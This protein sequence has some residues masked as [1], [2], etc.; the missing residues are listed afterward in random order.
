MLDPMSAQPR[1]APAAADVAPR[2]ESP[3]Y[4][5]WV[6]FVLFWVQAL[7]IVDRH[8]FG[9][10]I[11]G[12][13]QEFGL[14]DQVLGALAGLAFAIFYSVAGIPVARWAD[15]GVRRSIIALSLLLW[16]AMT[17]ACGLAQ[18]AWQLALARVLVG[19]GEAGGSPPTHSLVTDYFPLERRG[20]AMGLVSMGGSVGIVISLALG[21]WIVHHWGWREAFLVMGIPGIALAIVI[22]MSLREPPRGRFDAPGTSVAPVSLGETFR[23]LVSVPAFLHISL[24]GSLYSLAGY[25]G[26]IWNPTFLGRVHGLNMAEAGIELSLRSAIFAIISVAG[27]GFL[28]DWLARRDVR[29]YQWMPALAG[30]VH[31]PF[32]V[33]FLLWPDGQ[34]GLWFLIPSSLLGGL[35]AAPGHAMVQSLVRP[36]MRATA[37]ALMLLMFNLIGFGV[38]PWLVGLFNDL[39]EPNLGAEAV[40]YSLLIISVTSLWAALHNYLAARTLARDLRAKDLA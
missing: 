31:Y 25:G 21:G 16:S 15:R 10:A 22:Q 6:V 1:L 4:L 35:W 7:N 5:G 11:P 14:S 36:Q 26:A 9:L 37:S 32:V 38:G 18:S 34:T 27:G 13:K 17:A 20:R 19:V 3:A 28:G 40:R 30:L 12:I 24:A 23:F 33:A 29:W 2:S 8:V 39:L